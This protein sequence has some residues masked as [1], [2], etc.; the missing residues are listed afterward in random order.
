MPNR[1]SALV[2][3]F[4]V[5]LRPLYC[6]QLRASLF[7][8]SGWALAYI[9]PPPQRNLCGW[10]H[11]SGHCLFHGSPSVSQTFF[12][13][14]MHASFL[15]PLPVFRGPF[16]LSSAVPLSGPYREDRDRHSAP[17]KVCLPVWSALVLN[18]SAQTLP[19]HTQQFPPNTCPQE[20]PKLYPSVPFLHYFISLR[21]CTDSVHLT[22]LCYAQ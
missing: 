12:F 11:W 6:K 20:R 10:Q 14:S 3:L 16:L 4:H 13:L 19:T 1:E 18:K 7:G 22:P 9:S 2:A 8:L 15:S 17:P 21:S 5:R